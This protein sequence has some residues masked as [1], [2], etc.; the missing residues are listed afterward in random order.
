MALRSN[1]LRAA[2]GLRLAPRV[3]IKRRTFTSSVS[4]LEQQTQNP[5][6]FK[7]GMSAFRPFGAPFIKVFLGAIF[8]YQLIYFTWMKLETWEN[9]K[10]KNEEM[11]ALEKKA[12]ELAASAK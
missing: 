9:K 11:Q 4:R 12:K 1:I 10:L 8:S 5:S 7:E 2:A 6:S 3:F